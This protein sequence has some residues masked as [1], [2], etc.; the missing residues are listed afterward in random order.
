[1]TGKTETYKRIVS[2]EKLYRKEVEMEIRAYH[3]TAGPLGTKWLEALKQGVLKAA[4]CSKCGA[5]YMPPKIY[6]PRC[7]SEVS[8]LVDI[9][10]EGFVESY[11]IIYR[12]SEGK[13]LEKPEIMALIRFPGVYGGLIHRINIDP[14]EIRIGIKV[15]PVF[16]EIRRGSIDDIEYFT[17]TS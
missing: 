9:N 12:D 5:I 11:T 6:C 1:M 8:E 2:I 13:R 7:F 4:K 14:K 15:K 16:R 10:S 17:K 3:Y